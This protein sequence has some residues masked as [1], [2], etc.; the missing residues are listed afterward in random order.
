MNSRD[1]RRRA[2]AAADSFDRVDFVHALTRKGLLERLRPVAIDASTV[3]D[4]GSATG[5]GCRPLAKRFRGAHVVAVDLSHAMLRK[6]KEKQ[7][8]FG[9]PSFVQADATALPFSDHSADVVFSNLLLPWVEDPP[10]LFA[11]IA[12]VLRRGGLFAFSTL[13]PDSLVQLRQAWDAVDEGP[14]VNPFPDM[15]DIGD[16]VVRAGLR[17]PVLDV[18]RTAVSYES[19]GALFADLTAMGARN[20]QRQRRRSL[21]GRS[22]FQAMLRA[23]EGG[24]QNGRLCFD[25]ELVYGHCWGSGPVAGS[26]E[27]RIDPARIRRRRG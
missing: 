7:G 9:R 27:V 24:R 4:L 19:A 26:G 16:A 21:V 17:D 11:E 12:R 22:Q 3:I 13:G 25:L 23:L 20:S 5:A 1:V 10:Q 8:W 14:H 15:H 18:D 2:D 6:A